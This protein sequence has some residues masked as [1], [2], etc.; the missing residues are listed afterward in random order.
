M[1]KK[2]IQTII[3]ARLDQLHNLKSSEY[4]N[5]VVSEEE[6]DAYIEAIQDAKKAVK[7]A[8][9]LEHQLASP[10]DQLINLLNLVGNS[11][12][13]FT[14]I[15]VQGKHMPHDVFL[16][17]L[18]KIEAMNE[19]DETIALLGGNVDGKPINIR[20]KADEHGNQYWAVEYVYNFDEEAPHNLRKKECSL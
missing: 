14:Q 2:D 1:K 10:N 15:Q 17:L 20:I 19:L 11:F 12:D 4:H 16:D 13:H 7:S 8:F 18:P 5:S 3:N 9:E 6:R